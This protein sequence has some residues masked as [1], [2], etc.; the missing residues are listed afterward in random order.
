VGP[1]VTRQ[2]ALPW[3]VPF[4][5][6]DGRVFPCCHAA[7]RNSNQLGRI[8][9]E[10]FE[11]IWT[12]VEFRRFRMGLLDG[13]PPS[14][15][16]DCT[17]APLGEHPFRLWAARV[18]PETVTLHGDRA[19]LK[20]VNIGSRTW[21]PADNV[22]IG[23]SRPRDRVS[24]V[25][26]DG[27]LSGNRAAA[28]ASVVAPG[29]TATFSFSLAQPPRAVEEEFELVVEGEC[30]IPNTHFSLVIPATRPLLRRLGRRRLTTSWSAP[31][32]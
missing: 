19:S 15:C 18:I 20:V 3:E 12:G 14:I 5:D 28:C 32:K 4:V 31:H 6:K 13:D 22:R 29:E 23:T 11:R 10:G 24:S 16:R 1:G 26:H 25:S 27:W 9:S 30:W 7:A 21:T 8:G 2:C 17:I